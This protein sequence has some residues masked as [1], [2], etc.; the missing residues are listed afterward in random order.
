MLDVQTTL[1]A[2]CLAENYGYWHSL[3]LDQHGE[4]D[5]KLKWGDWKKDARCR[6]NP[7]DSLCLDVEK[8][9]I[10]IWN[11]WPFFEH[12]GWQPL[13][14]TKCII[15]LPTILWWWAISMSYCDQPLPAGRNILP[16]IDRSF[17]LLFFFLYLLESSSRKTK[18]IN[19]P[20]RKRRHALFYP[21]SLDSMTSS[22][23]KVS[24]SILYSFYL[25][26][27]S[28]RVRI[29]ES[30]RE[31]P[32]WWTFLSGWIALNL[33][34]I[35]YRIQPV[36]LLKGEAVGAWFSGYFRVMS[37]FRSPLMNTER[38]TARAKY[39]SVHSD[40]SDEIEK[41]DSF[42][43]GTSDRRQEV[44]AIGIRSSVFIRSFIPSFSF[45]SSNIWTKHTPLLPDY[46]PQSRSVGIRFVWSARSLLPVF[47]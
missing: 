4:E 39:R 44:H 47:R 33:K 3:Y 36:N 26:S 13:M 31:D 11:D 12:Y 17:S 2:I 5:Q 27:S 16:S 19:Q 15:G 22:A 43:A 24:Q 10:S 18:E 20:T 46:Y 28:Y 6:T 35:P 7:N 40:G 21:P 23:V 37:F 25:S 41:T 32:S 45:R 29:G 1:I 14:I 34:K 42:A 38:S 30:K 8:H 9:C